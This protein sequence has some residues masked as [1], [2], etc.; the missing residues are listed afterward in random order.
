MVAHGCGPSYS[1][2]LGRRIARAQEVETAVSHDHTTVLQPVLYG[3]RARSHLK[4]K[5]QKKENVI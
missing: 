3:D 1:G 5:K 2:G 4:N